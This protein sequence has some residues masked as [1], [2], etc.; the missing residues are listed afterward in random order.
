V[1]F[2]VISSIA[3]VSN[4]VYRTFWQKLSITDENKDDSFTD[5]RYRWSKSNSLKI[6]RTIDTQHRA[7]HS[8]QLSLLQV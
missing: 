3:K 7:V 4:A 6:N 5:Y 8:R 2:N 1:T